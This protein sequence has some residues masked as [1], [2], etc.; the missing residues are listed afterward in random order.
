MIIKTLELQSALK[1]LRSVIPNRSTIPILENVCFVKRQSLMIVGSD[2]EQYMGISIEA[3]D[4]FECCLPYERLFKTVSSLNTLI[5]EFELNGTTVTITSDKSK[6]V[7]PYLSTED[8]PLTPSFEYEYSLEVDANAFKGALNLVSP[9]VSNDDLRP[10]MSAI[11][12]VVNQGT[13]TLYGSDGHVLVRTSIPVDSADKLSTSVSSSMVKSLSNFKDE[14]LSLFISD[15]HFCIQGDSTV[16]YV[17]LV[18]GTMP[19]FESVWPTGDVSAVSEVMASVLSRAVNLAT[20]YTDRSASL[21][22]IAFGNGINIEA[23][24]IDYATSASVK[25][26]CDGS[27]EAV[28]GLKATLFSAILHSMKNTIVKLTIRDKSKAVVF[29]TPYCDGLIMP[30]SYD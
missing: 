11:N 10:I 4:A 20:L 27:G 25:C 15:K 14:R 26:D 5:I 1:A 12:M 7:L 19:N 21:I 2:L 23:K 30:M 17:R 6:F 18:E 22:K 28:I 13:M 3:Q 8:Y 16:Y 9:F 24:D 29:E